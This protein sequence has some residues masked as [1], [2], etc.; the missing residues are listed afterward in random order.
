M[1][2]S[3]PGW[4]RACHPL[5]S[6]SRG[7]GLLGAHCHAWHI[8]SNQ[9]TTL[10]NLGKHLPRWARDIAQQQELPLGKHKVKFNSRTKT[11][12]NT[13]QGSKPFPRPQ[14]QAVQ[15]RFP[16]RPAFQ[17]SEPLLFPSVLSRTHK[18]PEEPLPLLR[19]AWATA[20]A[21]RCPYHHPESPRPRTG[22][23]TRSWYHR[24][25]LFTGNHVCAVLSLPAQKEN[26]T[27]IYS[28]A[29]HAL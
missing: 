5:A 27:F 9:K 26:S 14:Q 24:I 16:S 18:C 29:K 23:A 6:V 10:G 22:D 12:Q 20:R 19:I 13:Q 25:D 2:L 11:K 8:L 3:Y 4:P 17:V 21:A 7:A 28:L 15:P 1:S